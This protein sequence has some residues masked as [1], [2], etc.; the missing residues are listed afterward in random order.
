MAFSGTGKIWMNGK[1][2]DWKDATI[3]VASHVDPL[4]QRRVRR[5]AVLQH[6]AR[7]GLL[8]ARCPHAPAV[9]LLQ[10]LPDGAAARSGKPDRGG[11]RDDSRQSVQGL[12]HPPDRLSRLQRARRQ[13]VPV[14]GRYR[15]SDVG[16]G[17]VSRHR[18]RW[19]RASTCAS[20]RGRART[21]TR[22]RRWRS[23][24][25]TTRTRS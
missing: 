21:R 16:M 19:R 25:R 8:P 9:R 13:P 1:L 24:R 2:V 6:A 12:L 22:S 17:R 20:A 15:D 14:P 5:S 10:D 11:P 3:H 18:T 7:V 23:R 4:R